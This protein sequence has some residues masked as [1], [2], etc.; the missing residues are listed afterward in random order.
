MKD[1][2][3]KVMAVVIIVNAIFLLGIVVATYAYIRASIINIG[4]NTSITAGASTSNLVFNEGSPLVLNV[5]EDNL[6]RGGNNVTASSTSTVSLTANPSSSVSKS[7]E[8]ILFIP[9]NTFGYTT[10]AN[11]PEILLTVVKNGVTIIDNQ[12]I[13]TRKANIKIG[14]SSAN[15]ASTVHTISATAGN[16]QIDTW[17]VTITFVNLLTDQEL[18]EGKQLNAALYFNPR[19]HDSEL[20]ISYVQFDLSSNYGYI[21]TGLS[22]FSNTNYKIEAAFKPNTGM[23]RYPLFGAEGDFVVRYSGNSSNSAPYY[24]YSI[25][26]SG[27]IENSHHIENDYVVY[28][29]ERNNNILKTQIVGLPAVEQEINVSFSNNNLLIFAPDIQSSSNFGEVSLLFFRIYIDGTLVRNFIPVAKSVSISY[30]VDGLYD[31]VQG[32]FYE[33]IDE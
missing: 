21:D 14:V 31:L 15:N 26:T 25:I 30:D 28:T 4:A 10:G 2:K 17:L 33:A 22:V 32:Q 11:T 9:L 1:K 23:V 13:T 6:S 12:D 27:L 24:D 18:N 7:Y 16:T 5:N 8:A 20:P 3:K 19:N 29:M